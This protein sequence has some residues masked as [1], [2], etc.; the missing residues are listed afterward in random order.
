MGCTAS[1]DPGP[2]PAADE[3][4]AYVLQHP[5]T[6]TGMFW[7]Q[8]PPGRTHRGRVG[9]KPD[10]PRNGAVLKGYVHDLSPQ[11]PHDSKL[12][13]EVTEFRQAGEKEWVNTPTCW[14]QFEQ[15][16]LLLHRAANEA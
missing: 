9:A 7:R 2:I 6:C 4:T 11:A 16:G 10:W 1:T 5:G 14:M 13:L 12:W 15:G 3:L 8:A